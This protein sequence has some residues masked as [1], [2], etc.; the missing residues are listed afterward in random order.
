ME[1]ILGP[2]MYKHACA[3]AAI[4]NKNAAHYNMVRPGYMLYGYYPG[5]SLKEKVLLKP[6]LKFVSVI[7]QIKEYDEG[8]PISYNRKYI[9]KRKTRIATV[10]AGYSDGIRRR[11]FNAGYDKNG[12][13]VV[14]GQRAPITG[15]VCM[16][17]TMIDITG[18]EGEVN[19]GDEVAIFDNINVTVEEMADICGTIGYEIISQIEDKADRVESF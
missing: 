17:L 14:N 4:F 9:T 7:L 16:D 18:I 15:S 2:V 8:T 1:S 12:C 10:S 5:N 19:A 11:L 6:A 13:F 3:G